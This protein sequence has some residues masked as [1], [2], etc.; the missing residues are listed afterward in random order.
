MVIADRKNCKEIK[1]TREIYAADGQVWRI[2]H[3]FY[4]KLSRI[5]LKIF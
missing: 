5:Y 1:Q 4:T 3:D 2:R